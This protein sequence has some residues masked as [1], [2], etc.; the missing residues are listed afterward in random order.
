M[1]LLKSLVVYKG[2]PIIFS[3]SLMQVMQEKKAQKLI[4]SNNKSLSI[5]LDYLAQF[6]KLNK[7]ALC[8]RQFFIR[9]LHV[10]H[11]QI[12]VA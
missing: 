7:I 10:M 5:Q 4:S 6:L 9:P 2:D 8:T 11:N 1:S 3:D 12:G